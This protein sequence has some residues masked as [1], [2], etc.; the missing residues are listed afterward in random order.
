MKNFDD[1]T[2][3]YDGTA[4]ASRLLGRARLSAATGRLAFD[5]RSRRGRLIVDDRLEAGPVG[6]TVDDQIVG[7]VLEPVDRALGEQR[8]VEGGEP[9]GR[10]AIARD[11]GRYA[12]VTV[13]EELI[14]ISTLLAGHRLE[15]EVVDDEQVEADHQPYSDFLGIFEGAHHPV[16]AVTV[17]DPD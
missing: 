4:L 16:K 17:G 11:D 6:L 3:F 10:V 13:D 2:V 5:D 15:R 12:R 14:D 9:L 7:V 1:R 8:V